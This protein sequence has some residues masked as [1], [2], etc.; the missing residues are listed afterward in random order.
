MRMSIDEPRNH[1]AAAQVEFACRDGREIA[2]MGTHTQNPAAADQQVTNAEVL[3]REN[4]RVLE[5]LKQRRA[6]AAKRPI[7]YTTDLAA[8]R[9]KTYQMD[10][11]PLG[12]ATEYPQEYNPGLLYGVPRID[13]R[14]ELRIGDDLPFTG[15]DT[16]NAWELT[17]LNDRGKPLVATAVIH[18]PAASPSLIESKSLKLYLNSLSMSRYSDDSAVASLIAADLS[19]VAGDDVRIDM[20]GGKTWEVQTFDKLPGKCLDDIDIRCETTAPV[21]TLLSTGDA[22]VEHRE[23]HSHLLRSNCP[24]TG[25]PDSGSVLIRYSGPTIDDAGLL[26]YLVSYRQHTGFHEACVENIFVDILRYCAPTQLTVHAH[27]NRRGGLDIN[28]F[29]SNFEPCMNHGRLWRQ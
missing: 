13:A 5:K 1:P 17:W 23:L 7:Y 3:G 2:G 18:V 9:R 26:G 14:R 10:S 28:P 29:R 8:N 20:F 22:M 16:W 24:V 11:I 4:V 6:P 21:P 27:Y 25:Q 15:V 12:Q 19:R